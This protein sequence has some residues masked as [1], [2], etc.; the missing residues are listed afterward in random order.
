MDSIK[1][2]AFGAAGRLGLNEPTTI[3]MA[4]GGSMVAG[5]ALSK[6]KGISAPPPRSYLGEM[7]DALKSQSAVQGQLLDLERQ[8]TPQYQDLQK[9]SLMGQMGTLNELYGQ[10]GQYSQNLQAQYAGMQ[11][12][13]Y[14]A[15]GQMSNQAYQQGLSADTIGLYNTMQRQAQ[16]G[17]DA[18][19]G[20]T[21]EMQ[22][23]A[24]QS[25]RAAM[26]SRGLAM[27]NQGIAAE[28]LNSYDLGNKRYQQSLANAQGAYGLGVSQFTNSMNTYGNTM[29]QNMSAYNP[30]ALVAGAMGQYG[31][32]GAKIFQPES[33]Y[34]AGIYG[35]NQSNEMQTRMANQQID[36][37]FSTGL[38][39]AGAMIASAGIKK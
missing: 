18:G 30:N 6:P 36:S 21:P 24:Q 13:L 14:N 1:Y 16:A 38:M 9:T 35:A 2:G 26:T 31:A 20:L 34:N 7:Q 3:A 22:Q 39:S 32:L 5:G 23:Q 25:A 11:M 37:A 8:Y 4:V 19:F 15:V 17:L 33:Q 29:I 27:G 28:V 10:A 12:P